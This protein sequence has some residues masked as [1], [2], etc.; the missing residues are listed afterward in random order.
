MHQKIS[1]T[2]LSV[3]DR[4]FYVKGSVCAKPILA[5]NLFSHSLC[6]KQKKWFL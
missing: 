1:F 3:Q 2:L 5:D 6:Q 4:T